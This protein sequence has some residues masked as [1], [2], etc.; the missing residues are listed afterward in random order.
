MRDAGARE[1]VRQG[2]ELKRIRFEHDDVRSVGKLAWGR[3]A[4]CMG[5]LSG[6]DARWKIGAGNDVVG[7]G[8]AI[9]G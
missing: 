5:N 8:G 7:E 6:F 4:G 2:G 9:G 1:I 3:F